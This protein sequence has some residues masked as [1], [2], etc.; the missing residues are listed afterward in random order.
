MTAPAF[1]HPTVQPGTDPCGLPVPPRLVAGVAPRLV[2]VSDDPDR[3]R[4]SEYLRAV[5]VRL[6]DTPDGWRTDPEAD[7]LIAYA[8]HRFTQ[9]ARKHGLQ[10]DDAMACR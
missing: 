6:C 10:P 1:D 4:D 9:L 5:L 3:F 8:G 7:E 2:A